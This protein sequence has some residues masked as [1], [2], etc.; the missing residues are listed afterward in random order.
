MVRRTYT[1]PSIPQTTPVSSS[2]SGTAPGK[3]SGVNIF[4]IVMFVL[5]AAMAGLY[6]SIWS[7]DKSVSVKKIN[8]PLP[9]PKNTSS[10]P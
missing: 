5:F 1:T 7:L 9:V 10:G 6:Y 4:A 2:S 3:K 8:A